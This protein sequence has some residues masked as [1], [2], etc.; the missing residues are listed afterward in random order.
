MLIG[1]LWVGQGTDLI[2]NSPV[3]SGKPEW[4]IIG[5]VVLVVGMLLLRTV[6]PKRRVSTR[7][8]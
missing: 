2:S 8:D 3:M 6:M 4:A 7:P 5:L 1:L